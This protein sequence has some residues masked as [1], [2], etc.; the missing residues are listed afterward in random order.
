[1][2]KA[3]KNATLFKTILFVFYAFI[4][5][6]LTKLSSIDPSNPVLLD[7]DSFNKNLKS[8]SYLSISFLGIMWILSK[9]GWRLFWITPGLRYI[10]NRFVCPNLNGKWKGKVFSNYKD[11]NGNDISKDVEI[12]ISAD[13]LD[14]DIKLKSDDDYSN[15]KVIMSDIYRD[16]RTG[17]FY[18]SYIFEGYVPRPKPTDDRYFEGA[19]I[20]EI[21]FT[22]TG[23]FGKNIIKLEGTYWTNRAWQ[24]NKNTAGLISLIQA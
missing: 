4:L 17:T 24:R 3:F 14:F 1:M 10:L 13:L 5:L 22:E 7:W 12:S 21:K 20:L 23:F 2:W 19:A 16:A 15:S 9:W 11:D 6:V 8:A 18:I